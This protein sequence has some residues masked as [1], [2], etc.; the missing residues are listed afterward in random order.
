MDYRALLV[1][2]IDYVGEMEGVTYISQLS[3][4]SV[5]EPFT[6]EEIA[7]L[8]VLDTEPSIGL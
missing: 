4:E 3:E 2:Y 7:E 6:R 8:K 5:R 1:K